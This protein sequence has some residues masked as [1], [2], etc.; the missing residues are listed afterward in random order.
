MQVKEVMSDY[1]VVVQDTEQVAYAR[2]LMLKHGFS[3]IVVLNS[4]E[5]PV[6]IIS[7]KDITHKM[8][9]EG[10]NWKKRP[11]DKISIKRVMNSNLIT[12]SPEENIKQ[13]VDRMLKNDLSSLIVV[14]EEGLAGIL[15]KTDLLKAY[16]QKFA[17]KWKIADLMTPEVITV[18]EN[19]SINHVI[20]LMQEK[21]IGRIVVNR[22]SLPIGIITSKNISF[23]YIENPE[24]GVNMEKV[25][26]IRQID[27]EEKKN[28][29]MVSMLT[30]RDVMSNHL[31]VVEEDA[32]SLEASKL[33]LKEDI[34]GLPVVKNDELVGIITKTDIIKGIQ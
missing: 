4:D 2:N 16:V 33:M 17:G 3:R 9:G 29:K 15:T 34:S 1:V 22:K 32:D 23:A 27:G 7:E 30:A 21:N 28:V 25:Y 20:N 6:G 13:A 11:I 14:D 24:T 26:F 31:L 19:H 18:D 12:I 10:P 5:K 8:G